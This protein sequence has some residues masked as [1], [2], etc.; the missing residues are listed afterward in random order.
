MKRLFA[1]LSSTFLFGALFAQITSIGTLPTS[2]Q[3][4]T[5]LMRTLAS[6]G[7]K[8]IEQGTT[9]CTLHNLD[10]SIYATITYPAPPAGFEWSTGLP[11]YITEDLFDTDPSTIEYLMIATETGVIDS[12]AT[13]VLRADGTLVFWIDDEVTYSIG[14][15]IPYTISPYVFNTPDGAVLVTKR[16]IPDQDEDEAHYYQLPGMLPCIEC[17]GSL[18]ASMMHVGLQE[19]MPPPPQDV[20]T[21]PNPANTTTEIVFTTITANVLA[22]QLVDMDGRTVKRIPI[23]AG[24]QRLTVSVADVAA[25]SYAY[26]LESDQ[27]I[28]PGTRLVVVR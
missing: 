18:S 10:L 11:G 17:D 28:I 6:A 9:G 2:L 14:G 7:P 3:H 5:K 21:F 12:Y 26:W 23:T 15:E 13:A 4:P 20:V 1:L 19:D 22:V 24:V 8:L 25:G 16:D 27:G